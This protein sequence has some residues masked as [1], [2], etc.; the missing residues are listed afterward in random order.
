MRR[1]FPAWMKPRLLAALACAGS[2]AASAPLAIPAAPTGAPPEPARREAAPPSARPRQLIP[3]AAARV[4]DGDTVE[5]RALV[6]IDHQVTA[7]VRL[8]GIDAPERDGRCPDEA[9]RA[10]GA[11]EALA[12]LLDDGPLFLTDLG[13]DKFGGRVL[14]RL[15]L[16]TGR[17]AGEE[18]LAAGH[19]RPYGGG[20]R[21]RRCA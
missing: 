19:A 14:G 10:A 16:G 3:I 6:W 20:R 12:R 5:V 15:V 18:L 21:D 17:D 7:R 4:I 1:S 11:A 9:R 2:I 8:R 13:R